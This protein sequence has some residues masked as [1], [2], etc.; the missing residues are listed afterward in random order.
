VG[1]GTGNKDQTVAHISNLLQ[2]DEQIV[3]L[4]GGANGPLLTYEGIYSK[5][6]RMVEAMDLKGIEQYYNDPKQGEE[7]SA[8]V[9]PNN[10]QGGPTPEQAQAD[11]QVQIEQHKAE[12]Q[13][14]TDME[15][16]QLEAQTKIEVAKIAADAQIIVAGMRVPPGLD[17]GGANAEPETPSETASEPQGEA[18]DLHEPS[19]ALGALHGAQIAS[20]P[21]EMGQ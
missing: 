13:A 8:P 9:D 12:I 4:Q 2:I 20:Q 5:L 17:A 1:L 15:R 21:P 19:Y 18:D 10:P 11:A 16:A 14:Q 6:K 7:G 3:Q